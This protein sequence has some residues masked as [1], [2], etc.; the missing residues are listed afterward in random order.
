MTTNRSIACALCASL[1]GVGCIS[2]TDALPGGG[3]IV[4]SGRV[5]T[6]TRTVSDFSGVQVTG[7]ARMTIEQTG[8]ESLSITGDDNVIPVLISKVE[9]GTLILGP[10]SGTDIDMSTELF[11]RLT[12]KGVRN[13]HI[14]GVITVDAG[15]IETDLINTNLRGVSSLNIQGL[16]NQQFVNMTGVSSYLAANLESRQATVEADGVLTVVVQVSDRL[17]VLACGVGT[18]EYIG[19]P[20]VEL[21]NTCDGVGV[22]KR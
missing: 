9:N 12:V 15:R 18:V 6:V 19:D 16:V 17:D 7:A 10:P 1:L 20:L 14:D 11:Y 21:H 8:V 4:G 3:K 13:L 5:I 22:R 2:L